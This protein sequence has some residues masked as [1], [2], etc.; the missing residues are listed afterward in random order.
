[1]LLFDFPYHSVTER[2]PESST[3]VQFGGG[4]TFVSKPVAPDQRIFSLNFPALIYYTN[5]NGSADRSINPKVNLWKLRDFYQAHRL[6][7]MFVYELPADDGNRVT[8]RFNKPLEIPAGVPGGTG[9]VQ[10]I[11]VELIEQ[12]GITPTVT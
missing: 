5:P 6:Y 3:R 1:M 9:V 7:E 10:G 8:V 11:Q 4:Y 12:P 2:Y